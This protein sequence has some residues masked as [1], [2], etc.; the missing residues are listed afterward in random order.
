MLDPCA[1][2]AEP[3]GSTGVPPVGERVSRSQAFEN[4]R[5]FRR[6]A[7]THGRDA[8]APRICPRLLH[9]YFFGGVEVAGAAPPSSTPN[10]QCVSIFLP[11]DFALR[12]TV[13]DLSRSFWVT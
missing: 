6:D 2:G 4:Q 5:S 7:E 9:P 8:R 11:S 10:V 1:R 3:L 13:H 12:I